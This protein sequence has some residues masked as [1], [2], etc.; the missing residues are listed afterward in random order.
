VPLKQFEWFESKLDY[1]IENPKRSLNLN[2]KLNIPSIWSTLISAM[3]TV[4]LLAI[5][6]VFSFF[7]ENY[8]SCTKQ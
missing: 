7:M 8:L 1:T 4:L 6:L 2:F 5:Q 3:T